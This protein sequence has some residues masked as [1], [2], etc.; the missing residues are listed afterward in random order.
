M[1]DKPG[2]FSGNAENVD[3][4]DIAMTGRAY[5]DNLVGE[6]AVSKVMHLMADEIEKLRKQKSSTSDDELDRMDA[7][8]HLLPPPGG[9]V[10]GQLIAEVRSLKPTKEEQE[11]IA[12]AVVAAKLEAAKTYGKF[13]EFCERRAATMQTYLERTR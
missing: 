2:D 8:R 1:S 3:W 7:A 13:S 12:W 4:S 9:E 6:E 10:V 5:A 11:A